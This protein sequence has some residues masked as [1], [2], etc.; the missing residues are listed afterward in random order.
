LLP[1]NLNVRRARDADLT[2]MARVYL[3]AFTGSGMTLE[4][5]IDRF[6]SNPQISLEDFW[7]CERDAKI[8]G[9]FAIYNFLIYRNGRKVPA[10]GIGSVAVSAEAR[11]ERIAYWMMLRAVEIMDQNNVPLSILYPFRHSFYHHLGWGYTGKINMYR[12]HPESLPDYPE[13]KHV[14]AIISTDEQ[15]EIMLCYQKFARRNN[16]MVIRQDAQW[17]ESIFKNAQCYAF[18][19]EESGTVE[20]YLTFRYKPTDKGHQH[21]TTDIDV[22]DF[23]WNSRSALKGLLGFISSQRDQVNIVNFADQSGLP[24]N[25][26][27]KDPLMAEGVSNFHIGAETVHIG[28]GMMGRIVNLRKALMA[29]GNMGNVSGKVT[30]E[31]EDKLNPDNC[32][33]ITMEIIDGKAELLSRNSADIILKT[34]IATLSAIYWGSL[35]IMDAVVLNLLELDGKGDAGFIKSMFSLPAPQCM[36]YF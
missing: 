19:S 32:D 17:Y 18:R 8:T 31:I 21:V 25:Q 24:F 29:S 12:F 26:I 1:P 23:V 30:L 5:V 28:T 16:G 34:D 35:S 2:N 10:G 15:E 22:W 36:D 6:R 11:R 9:L 14:T 20:G 4:Q 3:S 27:L 33:P 13:R 7:V